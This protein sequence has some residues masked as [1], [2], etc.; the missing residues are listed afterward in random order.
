MHCTRPPSDD[1]LRTYPLDV[2]QMV[3][4]TV[5]LPQRAELLGLAHA[6]GVGLALEREHLHDGPQ[7][8]C[9]D[10]RG[11]QMQRG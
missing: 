1:P 7:V 11:K 3:G 4:E 8:S 5:V 2:C 10:D 6:L 9:G